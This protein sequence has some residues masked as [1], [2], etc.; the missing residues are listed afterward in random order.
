MNYYEKRQISSSDYESSYWNIITD[1][2]GKVRNRL[3]EEEKCIQNIQSELGFINSAPAGKVLDIGCGLGFLLKNIDNKHTKVGV[4]VS[5]FACDFASEHARIY[6]TPFEEID[7][8][9]EKYDIIIAHHVIEHVEDPEMF[10]EKIKKVMAP[11]GRLIL[12]TPDFKSVCAKLFGQNYRML[13]DKTHRSLFSF[14][15]LKQMLQDFGFEIIKFEFPYFESQYHNEENIIKMLDYDK[16][17]ISPACWGNF[18]TFYCAL[19]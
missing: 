15:S 11:N 7:F 1:P 16:N 5:K 3:D 6:N 8:V 9:Q 12:A 10:L 19:K 18:M 17:A 13:H 14:A 2:D 4:E